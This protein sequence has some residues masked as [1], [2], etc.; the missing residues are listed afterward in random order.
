MLG[1]LDHLDE[2]EPATQISRAPTK[3]E[4]GEDARA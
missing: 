4:D 3:Y 1:E 2:R